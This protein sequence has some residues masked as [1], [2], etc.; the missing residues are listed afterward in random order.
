MNGKVRRGFALTTLAALLALPCLDLIQTQAAGGIDMDQECSLT[1]SVD[2]GYADGSNDE[3]LEDFNQM[4]IPV[5]VYQVA[6]VDVTGQKFTPIGVFSK[7]KEDDGLNLNGVDNSTTAEEWRLLSEQ[8]ERIREAKE[9]EETGSVTV[10]KEDGNGQTAEGRIDGLTHGLY[11]VV[12]EASY[13]MDYTLQYRFTPYLT[14]LPSS[15]YAM[16]GEG[17]DEWIYHTTIGLKPETVLQYGKLNITKRLS[18]YNETLGQTSFVFLVEGRETP[19]GPVVYSNV[20]STTHGSA[21]DETVILEKIPAGLIVTVKEIYSGASYKIVGSDTDTAL[22]WSEAAVD[23]G[24]ADGKGPNGEASVTFVNEYDGGNRG[25]YGVENK[26]EWE[27]SGWKWENP[28]PKPEQG[29]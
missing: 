11:L 15:T 25:G 28:A 8:A 16:T 18:D 21:G 20:V 7:T 14:A 23:A 5:S 2:I 22:I 3:F 26:F 4:D 1:V 27:E 9:P 13:N 19:E 6:D 24:K 29:E 12:P 10:R 17:D